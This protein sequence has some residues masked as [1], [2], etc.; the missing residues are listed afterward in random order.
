PLADAIRQAVA[1]TDLEVRDVLRVHDGRYWSYLC[2]EPTCCPPEG[3][4]FNATAH[5][6]A[7]AMAASGRTV[8]ADRAALTATIAPV[9]GPAAET[10]QQETRRAE[11]IATR[12]IAGTT[13]TDSPVERRPVI[14][15][16]LTAVQAAITAYRDG[17]S[18]ELGGQFA[19]LA[20][21][22][23][24]LQVRDDAW[25]RMDPGHHDAHLRLWTDLTRRAQPGYVAAP[26]SLLAFTAWQ[27]GNGALANV[28][29]DRA[30]AD[31]PGYSMAQLLRDVIDAGTPPSMARLP[32]TPEEVAASYGDIAD[33]P[34][35]DDSD[36]QG[37]APSDTE[38][39][40]KA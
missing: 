3:T 30:L 24:S 8:L 40:T 22:L 5:P 35:P 25:A 39:G 26:A 18:I 21:V 28:A 12:L 4:P 11:R 20:V 32:M 31:D 23:T 9:T 15:K 27:G 29:L 17:G 14:E 7:A 16:G 13:G 34:S 10:M 36:S 6:A 37:T 33:E 38:T 2:T 1:G 19:W